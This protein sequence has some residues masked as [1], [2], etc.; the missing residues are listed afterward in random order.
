MGAIEGGREGGR[1][2]GKITS[3]SKLTATEEVCFVSDSR[4]PRRMPNILLLL[5]IRR[6]T[7]RREHRH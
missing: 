3:S 6:K 7:S 5:I 2:V 1:K 4:V